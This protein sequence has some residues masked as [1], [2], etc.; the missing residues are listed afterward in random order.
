MKPEEVADFPEFSGIFFDPAT[1]KS[2][3]ADGTDT[4]YTFERARWTGP[5]GLHFAWPWL[6]PVAFATH[7]TAVKVLGFA[8]AALQPHLSVD[9]DEE[10]KDLG[11]FTR[12]IERMI[13][14]KGAGREESFSAGWLANSII[15]HGLQTAG[16]YFQSEVRQAGFS[17]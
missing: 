2:Y 10:K 12:T 9:I 4:G 7:D 3:L 13:V 6:N 8:R 15:R 1:G 14:V 16:K 17:L 5:F 11:P